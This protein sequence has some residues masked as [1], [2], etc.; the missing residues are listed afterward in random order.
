[1]AIPAA[2][3][4]HRLML[5]RSLLDGGADTAVAAET[6]AVTGSAEQP[7]LVAAMG[8]MAIIAAPG[9]HRA[10]HPATGADFIMTGAAERTLFG[11]QQMGLGGTMRRMAGQTSPFSHRRM[12]MGFTGGDGSMAALAEPGAGFFQGKSG[13]W[14]GVGGAGLP[15]ASEAVA[16]SDGRV[17][18]RSRGERGMAGGGHTALVGAC[19]ISPTQR[20]TEKKPTEN[21]QQ[22]M[23]QQQTSSLAKVQL[24]EML[25]RR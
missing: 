12:G 19:G 16:G 22:P 5:G 17:G 4:G 18:N 7:R 11:N 9:P 13:G 8:H 21:S 24:D 1:M 10:V 25:S 2:P 14:S 15:V 3:F 20:H 6:D 23:D